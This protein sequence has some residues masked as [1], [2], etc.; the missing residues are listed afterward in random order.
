LKHAPPTH[1]LATTTT[2]TTQ[3]NFPDILLPAFNYQ[4]VTTALIFIIF[5][6]IGLLFVMNLVLAVA[7]ERFQ[8]GSTEVL[9]KALLKRV[10]QL[11]QVRGC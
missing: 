2:T 8:A 9:S 6:V 11:D 3:A 5:V 10:G 1:T 4:P 7:Y